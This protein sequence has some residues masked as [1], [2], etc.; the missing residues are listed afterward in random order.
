MKSTDTVLVVDD[1]E[2][3]LRWLELSLKKDY[4]VVSAT[5]SQEAEDIVMTQDVQAIV[6]DHQMPG[7]TGLSFFT[8]LKDTLPE[9]QRIL[10]TGLS[11]E[12]MF[13]QAINGG[14]IFRYLVKPIEKAKLRDVVRKAIERYHEAIEMKEYKKL[15]EE[16]Q[17]KVFQWK[18]W[19]RGAARDI[20]AF[21]EL[22]FGGFLALLLLLTL[23]GGFLIL[24]LYL[25]KAG[26]GLDF[27]EGF[28][29]LDMPFGG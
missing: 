10:L 12:D 16:E 27:I 13:L 6:C 19:L 2:Y 9:V 28:S 15:F 5:C 20:W 25:M 17:K 18:S 24:L 22:T 7:E 21:W 26:L 1:D 23:A 3:L 8:R 29:V 14:E 11:N 4:V